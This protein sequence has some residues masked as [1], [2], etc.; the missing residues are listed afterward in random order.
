MQGHFQLAALPHNLG[1]EPYLH[2]E[3]ERERLIACEHGEDEDVDEEVICLE[4]DHE[5]VNEANPREVSATK[6]MIKFHLRKPTTRIR[7]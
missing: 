7:G 4:G 3:E 2:P 6:G 5:S 1:Q